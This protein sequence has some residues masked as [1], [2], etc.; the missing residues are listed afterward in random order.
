MKKNMSSTILSKVEQVKND[1]DYLAGKIASQLQNSKSF[2]EENEIQ[3]LKFHGTYQQFDRDTATELKQKGLEKEFSFMIRTRIPG[4]I[5][6]YNQYIELDSLANQFSNSS[7]RIT[8]RQ[9]FQFHGVLKKNLKKTISN[10]SKMLITTYGAC[11]DVVRNVTTIAAPIKDIIHEKLRKD[12]EKISS[13]FVPKSTSYGQIWINGEKYEYKKKEPLYGKCY[14]PRKFKIGITIPEDNSVDVLTNDIAI[15]LIHKNSKVLGYN[16]AIGGGLGMTHNKPETFPYLAKP[17]LFCKPDYLENILEE[18][19]KIQRDFGDRTN[20]KHARLKYLVEEKGTDWFKKKIEKELKT[21]FDIPKKINNLKVIDHLGWH[22]QGDGKWYIG[23]FI[24]SGRIKDDKNI[25]IKSGLR[26]IIKTFKPS[27]ILST[28]QNIFLGDIQE[29]NKDLINKILKKNLIVNEITKINRWFLACPAL[30]TCGLALAEAERVRDSLVNKI[31]K[32][33]LKHNLSDEK[34]SIRITGCPNG[35]A[36]PYAGDIGI[37]GRTPNHYALYT[38]GDFEGSRLNRKI[39]DKVS[40][41]NLVLALEQ[42]FIFFKKN[43]INKEGFGDFCNRV[44][45]DIQFEKIKEILNDK[46]Q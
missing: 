34:I 22:E 31:D 46:V 25:K 12:A 36:R 41:E 11:G 37:I 5:L 45:T 30:P 7:L 3:L 29:K 21:N 8:T 42:L 33:L 35:C 38:G 1:S 13:N 26:D 6:D 39:V 32:I 9:T 24:P 15:F 19:I 18:I 20:R 44:G 43:K 17:V 40:Y 4:G 16:I 10:I 2:F 27:V 23:I 28:D 14:L